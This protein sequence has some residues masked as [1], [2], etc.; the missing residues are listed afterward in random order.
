MR[1]LLI[2]HEYTI[3]GA[4]LLMLRVAIHLRDRGHSCDVMSIL[5]HD[6]PLREQYAARG[7]QHRITAEFTDYDVVICNTIHAAPIVSPAAKFAKTVW[8]IHEGEN[9]LDYIRDAPS[10]WSAFADAAAIVFQTEHQRDIIYRAFVA[11]RE[12]GR[13]FV[14]PI[15]IDVPLSGP[16]I[17]KT[18]PFRLVSIGTIDERKRHSDLICAVD[19]L[20][21][22]DVEC[23][24]IG[25]YYWL[26]DSARR[27]AA[28]RPDLFRIFEASNADALAWLRPADLF[29]L[30]SG[31]ESQPV[32]VLEAAALGKPLV[33]TDLPSYRGIWQH[34]Q[35]CLVAAVGDIGGLG[36][37]LSELLANTELRRRLGA[38]ARTTAS[39]FTEAAFFARF[40]ATLEA[41]L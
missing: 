29:C 22:D 12:P 4:S 25:T 17:A 37:A 23:V 19:A 1:V 3:S 20:Q 18:R 34:R 5:S 10:A 13:L 15:G 8:W 28:S 27:I 24:I 7:I 35:N 26:D 2:N 6:G 38:A 41:V 21:R 14:I 36:S 40:D 11:D 32:A 16:S 9:G 30:P 39:Q 31:A 33:L